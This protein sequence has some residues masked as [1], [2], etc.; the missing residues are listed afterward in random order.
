MEEPEQFSPW[1]KSLIHILDLI[2][3]PVSLE[4]LH[5]VQ[6]SQWVQNALLKE[7]SRIM[8]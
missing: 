3:F 2:R 5:G 1:D 7:L 8:Y 4:E 6:S